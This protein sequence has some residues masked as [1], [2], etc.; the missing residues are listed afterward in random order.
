MA[1][2]LPRLAWRQICNFFDHELLRRYGSSEICQ[3]WERRGSLGQTILPSF[4]LT[5]VSTTATLPTLPKSSSRSLRLLKL[6]HSLRPTNL[7][8]LSFSAPTLS[9]PTVAPSPKPSL[10][11]ASFL[12]QSP[13]AL[14]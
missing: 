2:E 14:N 1:L 5:S 8:V 11:E 7:R 12:N 9:A 3:S 4:Y 10:T 6:L 13:S